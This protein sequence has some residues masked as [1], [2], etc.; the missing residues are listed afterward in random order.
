MYMQGVTN[1]FLWEEL[2]VYKDCFLFV[3]CLLLLHKVT[4]VCARSDCC[5]YRIYILC[6][7]DVTTV[8]A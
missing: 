2:S 6:E 4:T 5:V 3:F 1:V 7:Q 8:C